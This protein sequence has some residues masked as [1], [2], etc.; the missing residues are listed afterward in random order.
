VL[1]LDDDEWEPAAALVTRARAQ[2]ERHGLDYAAMALVFAVSALVRAQRGRV[3]PAR[4]DLREA[5]RLRSELVDVAPATEAEVSLMIARAALRLSDVSLGREQLAAA[6]RLVRRLPDAIA[7]HRWADGVEAQ[8]DA[9]SASAADEEHAS[10]TAAELRILQYLPT[11]MSF[12]EIGE[13]TYVSANTVK[14]QANAVYRKLGVSCRSEAVARAR[15][16][17]LLTGA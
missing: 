2:V 13:L 11:H 15:V 4:S 8:L 7:L 5:T 10:M 1:A 14:T 17:G 12:R 6:Q 9:F 3:D 16:C